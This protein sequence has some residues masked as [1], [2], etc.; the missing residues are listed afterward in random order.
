MS[1]DSTNHAVKKYK[2]PVNEIDE[3]DCYVVIAHFAD[4]TSSMSEVKQK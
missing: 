2:I 1:F 3:G 4:G